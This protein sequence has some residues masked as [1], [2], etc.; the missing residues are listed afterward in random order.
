MGLPRANCAQLF[1]WPSEMKWLDLCLRE[2]DFV[3]FAF[4][5][6][7]QDIPETKLGKSRLDGGMCG[8]RWKLG[9]CE[10]LDM[11]SLINPGHPA[12]AQAGMGTQGRWWWQGKAANEEISDHR[13]QFPREGSC[14]PAGCPG[15]FGNLCSWRYSRHT[16]TRP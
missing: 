10:V 6:V 7:P 9:A 8:Q 12:T 2:V 14:S 4:G 13:K 11:L 3:C 5:A 1:L 16:W 15:N